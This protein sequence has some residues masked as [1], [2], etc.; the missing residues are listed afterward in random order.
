MPPSSGTPTAN[1]PWQTVFGK[2]ENVVWVNGLSSI[3]DKTRRISALA[4]QIATLLG[5]KVELVQRAAH[6]CKNDLV[7]NMVGEV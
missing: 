6:L 7:T 1:K 3:A 4:N 2:L 5:A